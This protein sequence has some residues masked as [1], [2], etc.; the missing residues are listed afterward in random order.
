MLKEPK[1]LLFFCNVTI[2]ILCGY[3][4]VYI[5]S[6]FILQI[7]NQRQEDKWHICRNKKLTTSLFSSLFIFD[8]CGPLWHLLFLSVK[9]DFKRQHYTLQKKFRF[10]L[11]NKTEVE[12]KLP[13]GWA[14]QPFHHYGSIP[15]VNASQST[16]YYFDFFLITECS[17]CYCSDIRK[18]LLLNEPFL[19]RLTRFFSSTIAKR[20]FACQIWNCHFFRLLVFTGSLSR[21]QIL[22]LY[23]SAEFDTLVCSVVV[24]GSFWPGAVFLCSVW[25]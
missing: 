9:W 18:D 3:L 20:I 17:N 22:S 15:A 8:S 1:R 21:W 7:R 24:F 23:N 19:H 16:K 14:S 6:H 4:T 10:I 5:K 11:S 2:L 12:I 13:I 25:A